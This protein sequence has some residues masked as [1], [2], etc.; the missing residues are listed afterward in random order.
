MNEPN[1]PLTPEESAALVAHVRARLNA[2]VPGEGDQGVVDMAAMVLQCRIPERERGLLLREIEAHFL[3]HFDEADGL[4]TGAVR[5]LLIDW[6]DTATRGLCADAKARIRAEVSDHFEAAMAAAVANGDTRLDAALRAREELGCPNAARE[7]F[8]K[9]NLTPWEERQ[10]AQI[11]G[12]APAPSSR[13]RELQIALTVLG[14]PALAIMLF[15]LIVGGPTMG[16]LLLACWVP[17]TAVM[18]GQPLHRRFKLP[19]RTNLSIGIAFQAALMIFTLYLG[20]AVVVRD[21]IGWFD[22]YA[23]RQIFFGGTGGVIAMNLYFGVIIMLLHIRL[24]R[25]LPNTQHGVR[26]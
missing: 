8:L 2:R 5:P 24:L 25:K 3:A 14:V 15:L 9:S 12:R 6:L 4:G 1:T 22:I 17:H 23:E 7:R 20:G 19:L 26:S 18:I 11:E 13:M 21:V 16:A 10:I